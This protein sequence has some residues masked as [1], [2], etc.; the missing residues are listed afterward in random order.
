MLSYNSTGHY[1]CQHFFS[2]N[3]K[4]IFLF[5]SAQRIH[6]SNQMFRQNSF[7]KARRSAKYFLSSQMPLL[8]FR[9]ICSILRNISRFRIKKVNC[10]LKFKFRILLYFT[11]RIL[12]LLSFQSFFEICTNFATLCVKTDDC[13]LVWERNYFY[14]KILNHMSH[15]YRLATPIVKSMSYLKDIINS[16][17]MKN[18]KQYAQEI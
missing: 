16:N 17:N 7:V 11:A 4:N 12:K 8:I 15:L 3:I 10:F 14:I 6:T 18:I 9:K 13:G 2:E 1:F 5:R